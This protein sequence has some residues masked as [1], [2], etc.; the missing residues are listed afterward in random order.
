M[1]SLATSDIPLKAWMNIASCL[2]AK[3]IGKGLFV[4]MFEEKMADHFGSKEAIAVCNGTMADLVMLLALKEMY[5]G[6]EVILPAFTFVA[7]AN[8]IVHAGLKPVFVD[9]R[10]DTY[11]IDWEQVKVTTNTL[12]IFPVH[13]LGVDCEIPLKFMKHLGCTI[14]VL[15]DCCEAMGGRNHYGSFGTF[16]IGGS[17]SMFPSHTITTGEGGMII[18][19]S[20]DFSE[21]CRS[22]I[23]HGKYE[24][25]DFNFKYFGINAKMTNLQAAI[26]CAIVDSIDE[27]NKKRQKN[28]ALYNKLCGE[29]FKT[30]APHCYPVF[31]E[32]KEL[33]D[34]ALITLKKNEIEAR[35][36]MGCV[37]EYSFYKERFKNMGEF[38]VAKDVADR[39]LFVPIHQNLKESEIKRVCEVLD[40]TR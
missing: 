27:V 17:F 30:N 18:S 10:P 21:I 4:R 38:P 15:E 36:L 9:V 39:G 2:N 5:G 22:I 37:P 23:N 19:D 20:Q 6:N 7:H 3:R 26:G 34:M 29:N 14:P 40:E 24:S 31:Y 28:I 13:L 8:A 12:A 25:Q 1:I 11:Q 33:R 32:S 35:K 16:G